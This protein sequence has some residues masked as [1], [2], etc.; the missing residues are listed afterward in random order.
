MSEQRMM[1][2]ADVVRP[3]GNRDDASARGESMHKLADWLEKQPGLPTVP[4]TLT[5]TELWTGLEAFLQSLPAAAQSE[6]SV[7]HGDARLHLKQQA[8]D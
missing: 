2:L 8:L 3:R 6:A 4:A 7:Y 5:P 1:T